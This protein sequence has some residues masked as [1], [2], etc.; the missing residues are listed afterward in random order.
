MLAYGYKPL[1]GGHDE[2]VQLVDEAM[3]Q[4]SETTAANAFLVDVFPISEHIAYHVRY[5]NL[6]HSFSVKYIPSWF[7]GAGWKRKASLYHS[8]LQSML[9][10]PFDWVKQEMVTR[11]SPLQVSFTE[12]HRQVNGTARPSFIRTRLDNEG[13]SAEDEH[14]IKWAAAGIYSG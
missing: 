1:D 13:L 14:V 10:T 3:D 9:N 5:Q 4:F 8:T 6:D 7:P 12:M 2:L 11:L